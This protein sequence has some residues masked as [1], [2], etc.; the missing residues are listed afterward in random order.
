MWHRECKA[1]GLEGITSHTMRHAWASWQVQAKTP[2]RILQE[3]GG[4]ATLEMPLRY[5]H[6][7][8]GHLADYADRTLLS[9][10]SRRKTVRL[11]EGELEGDTQLTDFGGKGGGRTLGITR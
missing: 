5:T 9:E 8:S 3:L 10:D 11:E 4:W 1:A 2:L 6:P 7:D